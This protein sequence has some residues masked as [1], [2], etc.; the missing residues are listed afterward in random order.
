M[1]FNIRQ[2]LIVPIGLRQEFLQGFAWN[3][4]AKITEYFL[5]Y[6]FSVIVARTLGP[7]ANGTYATLISISQLLLAFSSVTFDLALNKYLPQFSESRAKIG[8]LVRRLLTAKVAVLAVLTVV[9]VVGWDTIQRWFDIHSPAASYLTFIIALSLFRAVSS[10]FVAICVS[11]LRPKAVF[12]INTATLMLQIIAVEV[13]VAGGSGISPILFIVVIGSLVSAVAYLITGR[14][15]LVVKA[16][17]VSMKPVVS[18]MGWLWINAFIAYVYGKQG[19]VAML[20]FFSVSKESVGF[21]DVASSLSLLPGFMIAAG[22][23]GISLS[24]FSRLSKEGQSSVVPFWTQLSSFL[25]RVTIPVYCFVAVFA[26]SII[27]VLYSGEYAESTLLVQVFVISRIVARLFGG[28]ENFDAMLSVD[29]E[30]QAVS[31]GIVGGII[32]IL[33][34]ILFIPILHVMG[35]VLATSIT[36][37]AIDGSMWLLLKRRLGAPLLV[38][39]WMKSLLVGILPVLAARIVF[40]T[41]GLVELMLSAL[42]CIFVWTFGIIALHRESGPK[43]DEVESTK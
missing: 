20:S 40:P 29:A 25:T 11:T 38:G 32:N 22:L 12:V 1:F 18:F 13:L 3:H 27:S 5:L 17:K 7:F 6:V 31:V 28:G 15:Y 36:T 19:D 9:L 43:V 30:R 35:A 37:L 8:Y 21:Y 4:A 42:F 24:I 39:N 10:F 33:L 26:G 23:S 14:N 2:K 41:P 34:N 16:E